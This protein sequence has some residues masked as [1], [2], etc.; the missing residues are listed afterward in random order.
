[1]NQAEELYNKILYNE[2]WEMEDLDRL[3]D[4]AKKEGAASCKASSVQV[5][6]V[7]DLELNMRI[8]AKK[9]VRALSDVLTFHSPPSS[10][11]P[12]LLRDFRKRLSEVLSIPEEILE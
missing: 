6:T 1:M 5:T 4:L 7:Q 10:L 8:T 12:L 9:A 11:S 3:L 2:D